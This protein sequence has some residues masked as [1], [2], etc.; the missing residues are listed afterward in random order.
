VKPR[1]QR[2]GGKLVVTGLPMA[3][4]LAVGTPLFH[5]ELDVDIPVR[6]IRE[7]DVPAEQLRLRDAMAAA[8][9]QLAE[10]ERRIEQQVG[11]SDARIFSVQGLLL[12]DPSFGTG[13]AERIAEG[14]V[15]AEVAVRDEVT[16]WSSKLKAVSV[17][18]GRDAGADLRDV[19]RQVL[20]VLVGHSAAVS[21][22]D[23]TERVV[24]VTRE[25][26]PSDA[27]VVDR[28]R[29]AAIVT[30]SGGAAS[31]AAILAR[32][33]GI[34]AVTGVDVL[35]LPARG[36]HW[37]VDGSAG[38][39]IVNPTAA[40]LAQAAQKSQ[41]YQQF[42]QELMAQSRGFACTAD[43]VAI[44]L[45]LNVENFEE[46]PAELLDDL[47]GVGLYRTEFLFMHRPFFPSEEEQFR[48]YV[49][50]LERVGDSEITFRTIDVGGDK[51]LPY[52]S[53]PSEPNPVLGWRGIRLSLEWPDMFYSQMRALLRASAH[54]R[55]RILLPMITMVEEFRRA[56]AIMAEIEA[57][58]RR[59]GVP[60]DP[61]VPLGAMVE[62]PAAALAARSLAEEADFLSIGTNDLSQY[63]LAVDR[64]NARVAALYQPLHPGLLQLVRMVVQAAD[65]AGTPVSLCGE[66]AGD[67]EATLLLLGIGLRSFS[68]S[69]YH[70]PVVKRVIGVVSLDEA[71]AV[72][73][74][75]M[76]LGSTTEV[77]ATLRRHTLRLVPELAAWLAP[78][79]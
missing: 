78:E 18:D 72:A 57:D 34:P 12:E 30:A 33:L 37:I 64:N 17:G 48:H 62:V 69:P 9:T 68:M 53:V 75:V 6:S 29:L 31:H 28:A 16:A 63:A 32:G 46:L 71:R 79:R 5:G 45:L 7:E 2:A 21:L 40:D 51:P 19:G 70:L 13:I 74:E 11:A 3:P 58:L 15:N 56:R 4:G 52:L 54:G 44:E 22:G 61:D 10:V 49:G 42:R 60:F 14:L 66:M 23:G 35:A 27:A 77:R 59:R 26:L 47:R 65:A 36:G 24:L 50:A 8:R 1:R 25:L 73:H 39:V 55:M 41:D 43:G 38:L 67:A 76:E 20:R